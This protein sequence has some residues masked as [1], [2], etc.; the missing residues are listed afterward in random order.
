MTNRQQDQHVTWRLKPDFVS[1][2]QWQENEILE[3]AV[4]NGKEEAINKDGFPH[5]REELRK[6]L[7]DDKTFEEHVRLVENK[8][9]DAM[10]KM[11]D[12]YI[13]GE[14]KMRTEHEENM[15]DLEG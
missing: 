3:Q 1:T 9:P 5:D 2:T 8:D 4:G 11:Y 14:K 15:K 7:G 10:K 13:N 12:Y 6:I